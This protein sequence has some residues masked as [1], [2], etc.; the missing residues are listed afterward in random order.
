MRSS[1]EMMNL[2]LEK[3]TLDPRIR[4]VTLEGSL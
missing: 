1:E 2:I 4:A 3:A